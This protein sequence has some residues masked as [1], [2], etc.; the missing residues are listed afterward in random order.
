[1]T[2]TKPC[3]AMAFKKCKECGGQVSSKAKACPSCG[4]PVVAEV[5]LI[6]QLILLAIIFGGGWWIVSGLMNCKP[7]A[8]ASQ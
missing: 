4:A 3:K 6:S 7:P 1:M 8:S 2:N 5:S